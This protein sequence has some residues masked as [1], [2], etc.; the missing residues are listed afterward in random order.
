MPSF[1][2]DFAAKPQNQTNLN[3]SSALRSQYVCSSRNGFFRLRQQGR[4]VFFV[5]FGGFAAKTNEINSFFRPA[6][7]E[8][9]VFAVVTA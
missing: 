3:G 5:R 4:T 7:G 2:F 9:K 8:N 6:G 1:S